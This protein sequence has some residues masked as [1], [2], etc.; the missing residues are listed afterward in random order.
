MCSRLTAF[1]PFEYPDEPVIC[2]PGVETRGH[3][4]VAS[5]R[6][7]RMLGPT[8]QA[9]GESQTTYGVSRSSA[10]PGE[11]VDAGTEGR[12]GIYSHCK[13]PHSRTP[14]K[15]T[16]QAS[17]YL[18]FFS[19]S[20]GA[21]SSDPQIAQ[22]LLHA[23]ST[24]IIY[25]LRLIP[26][27]SDVNSGTTSVLLELGKRVITSW[28]SWLQALSIEVNQRSGMY[29]HSTVEV[30]ASNLDSLANASTTTQPS[31]PTFGWTMPQQHSES[32]HAL[33]D[34]Y[35]DAMKP[36]RDRFVNELG[37][38]IGRHP[39]PSA[40]NPSN[41]PNLP[42]ASSWNTSSNMKMDDDEEL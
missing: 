27:T 17:T 37:W 16:S 34:S 41:M 3:G 26:P 6:S 23:L 10:Q 20:F 30:W 19:S 22:T 32:S 12:A 18:T 39:I 35:R 38:L 13:C 25:L 33:V 5:T 28:T 24:Q 31:T 14:A 11:G 40:F 15:L 1:S 2:P 36:I 42:A 21:R 4:E 7:E 8:G 9:Y 29:P